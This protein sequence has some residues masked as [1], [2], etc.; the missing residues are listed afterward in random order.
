MPAYY[1]LII[2]SL[3]TLEGIAIGIDP[4][5]KVLSVAYPYIANRI[6][7]DDAPALRKSL[8]NIL[9]KDGEF[10]WNRLENLLRNASS[11]EDYDLDNAAD[12]AIEFLLSERGEFL[13]S[14]L[15]DVMFSNT[16]NGNSGVDNLRRVLS[17]L[18]EDAQF[19]PLRF[20]PTL[21]KAALRREAQELGLQ[22]VSRWVQRSAAR[23]IRAWLLPDEKESSDEKE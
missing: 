12:R 2:R 22:L 17:V 1:A 18:Q 13:R 23:T 20:L 11:S 15:A 14:Q 7:T 21:G 4:D 10:R 19:E 3:L 8:Q 16:S 9:F 6:L 5:F